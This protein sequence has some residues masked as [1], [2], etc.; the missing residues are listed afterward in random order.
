MATHSEPV[1]P[2]FVERLQNNYKWK[3][4]YTYGTWPENKEQSWKESWYINNRD[5]WPRNR[6]T[7]STDIQ[8]KCQT[9]VQNWD[10]ASLGQFYV[11][12]FPWTD[13][14]GGL[15]WKKLGPLRWDAYE[16]SV[17]HPK[18]TCRHLNGVV[19]SSPP[20]PSRG[21]LTT[22]LRRDPLAPDLLGGS[23]SWIIHEAIALPP[24]LR[25]TTYCTNEWH[26][27]G[28]DRLS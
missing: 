22:T 15:G 8:T 25:H 21:W 3:K 16:I 20:H 23:P 9:L 13:L 2:T 28:Y 11:N 4:L 10:L 19:I 26:M 24:W 6:E 1:W 7:G 18:W 5:V 14:H 27:Y 12:W 17:I